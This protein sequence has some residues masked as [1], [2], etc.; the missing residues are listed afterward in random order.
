[1][2][3]G[4]AGGLSSVA[5]RGLINGRMATGR[6]RFVGVLA[7]AVVA[8]GCS[9]PQESVSTAVDPGGWE[10]DGVREMV[11]LNADTVAL[12]EIAVFA[13]TD[14]GSVARCDSLRLEVTVCTP[15]SLRLTE[16]V[17]L[18]FG[19]EYG[20]VTRRIFRSHALLSKEGP[21]RFAVRHTSDRP[22]RGVRAVGIEITKTDHGER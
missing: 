14:G 3:G 12:R 19:E 15:D 7:A 10:R 21:Y 11:L 18:P 6:S 1:M 16:R 4:A 22:L 5:R 8:A 9:G 2:N 17:V 13:L 20:S